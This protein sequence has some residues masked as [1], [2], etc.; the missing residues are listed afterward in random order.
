MRCLKV[1]KILSGAEK[2]LTLQQIAEATGLHA[3][4]AHRLLLPLVNLGF[5]EQQQDRRYHIG[6]EAVAV[7]AGFLRRSP[8]R[9]TAL[10]FLMRLAEQTRLTINLG[11]WLDGK[12]MIVDCLPM[13]GTYDFYEPGNVLPAHATA[14][15]K[16]LM[17]YRESSALA[18]F[19]PFTRY[20]ET[21]ICTIAELKADVVV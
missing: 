4:T 10:P 6:L 13:P 19:G 18:A 14:M 7:G 15:G 8:V 9:R 5:V 12:V 1:L 3:S 17:A 21:T 20:T 11:F 2:D 16:A